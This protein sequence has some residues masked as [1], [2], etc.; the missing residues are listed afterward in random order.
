[1]QPDVFQ[2]QDP[3]EFLNACF[4]AK[5]QA[6]PRFSLRAWTQQLGLGHVALLSMVLSR[7]RRLQPNLSAK[8]SRQWLASG[9]FSVNEARYFDFLVLFANARDP[10]EKEFYQRVLNSIAPEPTFTTLELDRLRI[11][12]D[13]YHFAILE[14]TRL[15]GFAPEPA[16]IHRQLGG[17]VSLGEVLEALRRLLR[18]GLLEKTPEGSLRK[19]SVYLATPS[20]VPD[21]ALRR[22]QAAWIQKAATALDTQPVTQRDITG[23]LMAICRDRLPEAKRRIREF[24]HELARFLEGEDADAVYQLNVQ[25]FEVAGECI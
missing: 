11:L 20:D 25:L 21:A 24:R 9:Q 17:Q 12:S 3:V 7:K 8:I 2:F 6:H 1:M 22:L 13:W 16:W 4:A 15:R 23:H 18:L 10:D 5:K 14:L 19:T